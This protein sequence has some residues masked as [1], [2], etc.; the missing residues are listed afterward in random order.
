MII[1]INFIH[2]I[3]DKRIHSENFKKDCKESNK[4]TTKCKGTKKLIRGW[5]VNKPII[6]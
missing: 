5:L 2:D 6:K 3:N 1:L 4:L